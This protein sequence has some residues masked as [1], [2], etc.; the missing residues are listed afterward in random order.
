M[1]DQSKEPVL[2]ENKPIIWARIINCD[3]TAAMFRNNEQRKNGGHAFERHS[4]PTTAA[5][6]D[7]TLKEIGANGG[8]RQALVNA[9]T[10]G[11]ALTVR[12]FKAVI[13]G[14]LA[15]AF[16]KIGGTL[17]GRVARLERTLEE[18]FFTTA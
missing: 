1:T 3:D 2:A 9:A 6:F 8:K 7:A 13:E 18:P 14:N 12:S 11:S 4:F 17:G 10:T 5:E 15:A 16:A